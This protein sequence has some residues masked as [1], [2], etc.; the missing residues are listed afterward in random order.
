NGVTQIVSQMTGYG[1]SSTLKNELQI[2]KSREFARQVAR[3]FIEQVDGDE[4]Q[5]PILWHED[6]ETGEL[7]QASVKTVANRIK[8]NINFYQVVEK[9]DVV[10]VAYKSKS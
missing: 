3:R 8:N 1:N 2:L 7:E 10:D 5:F 6:S 9:S 4:Q